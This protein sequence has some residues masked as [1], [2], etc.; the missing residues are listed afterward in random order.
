M[1]TYINQAVCSFSCVAPA[2]QMALGFYV[3]VTK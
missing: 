1:S 2:D 3:L